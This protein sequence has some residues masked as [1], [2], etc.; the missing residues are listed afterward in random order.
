MLNKKVVQY[1]ASVGGV[2]YCPKASGTAGSLVAVIIFAFM[3]TTTIA[4]TTLLL[5]WVGLVICKAS[6]E[7]FKKHDPKEFVLD[8]V[9]GMGLALIAIPLN[10]KY[11]IAAFVLFR[12]F[13]ILKPLGI[14]KL[15]EWGH[16]HAIMWDDVLAGIYA[17]LVLRALMHWTAF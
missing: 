11:W 9:V 15:D 2:G 3:A 14:R 7:V 4:I 17:N 16:P 5:L 13:D 10:W 8:E 12:F 6:Q 1:L